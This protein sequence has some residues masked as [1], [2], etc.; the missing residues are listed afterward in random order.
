MGLQ[1]SRIKK[2]ETGCVYA[3]VD[4]FDAVFSGEEVSASD[5]KLWQAQLN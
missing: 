4:S 2:A 3:A 5:E 1:S